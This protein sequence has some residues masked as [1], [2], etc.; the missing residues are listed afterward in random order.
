MK[1]VNYITVLFIIILFTKSS[2]SFTHIIEVSNFVFTPQNLNVSVGDTVKWVWVSGI[3][4]TTSTTIPQGAASWDEIISS[5]NQTYSYPVLVA[6]LYN[7]VCTPHIAMGMVGS[8]NAN[9]SNV[10]PIISSATDYQLLQNYPNP[11]NPTTKI[12]FSIPKSEFVTLLV[13]D[14]LG[15]EVAVLINEILPQ[16][17]YEYEFNTNKGYNISSGLYFYSLKTESFQSTRKMLLSK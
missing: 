3:H 1:K 15:R 10:V 5:A 13:Y 16:G 11:F 7:Y 4:T 17:V 6:G 14:L 2:F 8:F 12:Q 9:P